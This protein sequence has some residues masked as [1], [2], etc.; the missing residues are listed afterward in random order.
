MD[1][2]KSS[3]SDTPGAYQTSSPDSKLSK[4]VGTQIIGSSMNA[5]SGTSEPSVPD[6]IVNDQEGTSERK[7]KN[8]TPFGRP[9][10]RNIPFL[11]RASYHYRPPPGKETTRDTSDTG[12]GESVSQQDSKAADNT[13]GEVVVEE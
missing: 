3:A 8:L 2:S 13:E 1:S 10:R 5:Y 12:C 4:G 6:I 11:S 9:T 7:K